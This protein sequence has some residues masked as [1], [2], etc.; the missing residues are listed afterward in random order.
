MTNNRHNVP[1]VIFV[2]DVDH[3]VDYLCFLAQE[4]AAN[5]F[6]DR[7]FT[8]LPYLIPHQTQTVYFPD[9]N[10]PK[11]FLN[12]VKKT[13]K[14]VGQKFPT[15]ITQMVKPQIKVPAKLPAFDV[16]PFWT[17]LAQIGFFDFEIKTITVLLTPFGPGASFN[18]PSKGEIYLTFRAD[19]DISDLPR[20]IVSALV[21]YKN[22]R[23]G[24]S[25]ELYWKNRFYAEFLARDTILRKYCP[26][27]PQPE[28]RPEDLKA[29]QIYKQKYWFKAS[30]PLTL[31]F[32]K[33]LSPT[34][35][36]LFKRLFANRGQILT[37]DQIAQILW[38][39]DSLEKFS[40]WAVTKIIQKI[41]SK[42]KKHGGEANNL[43]TVYGKGYIIDI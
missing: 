4:I 6:T 38:G 43:K 10:Y 24:K 27:I 34:Q 29:A 16:K 30:K 31:E 13:G 15:V 18:F 11:K 41:R 20:S 26:V 22:G 21:L 7:N 9:L 3:Q 5:K 42:I 12:A 19:R 14:S 37:H 32:G 1:K 8:V 28:I 36:R 25:N 40:L 35:D 39:D 2:N 17:D 33:Y 23:P